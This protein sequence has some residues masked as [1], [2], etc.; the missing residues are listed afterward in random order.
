MAHRLVSAFV[1]LLGTGVCVRCGGQST[2][3]AD[4]RGPRGHVAGS[5]RTTQCNARVGP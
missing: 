4:N 2:A 3:E 5:L 1:L